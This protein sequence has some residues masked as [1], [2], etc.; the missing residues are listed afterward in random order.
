M[1]ECVNIMVCI[2]R[3]C[4]LTLVN[5]SSIIQCTCSWITNAS[6]DAELYTCTY[7]VPEVLIHVYISENVK[8]EIT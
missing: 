3:A 4:C 6:I 8:L 1:S 2:Y 5:Y 7:I